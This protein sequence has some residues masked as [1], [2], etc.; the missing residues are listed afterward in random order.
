MPLYNPLSSTGDVPIG[1]IL[2]WSGL[3]SAIPSGYALCDGSS[4]SPGPD[5][6]DRFIVGAKQDSGGVAK[7]NVSGSLL[8]S[9]GHATHSHTATGAAV[10]AHAGTAVSTHTLSTNVAIDAHAG[11]AVSTHTL[12]TNVS[13]TASHATVA[14]MAS[15]T[16]R[17][18][19]PTTTVAVG[20]TQPV[21]AAHSV[22]QPNAHAITQPVVAAHSVTQ[23]NAH[24]ITQPTISTTGTDESIPPFFALAFM[25][26][27]S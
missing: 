23:P 10:D 16:T 12:S 27:M 7:T 13:V 22:T 15:G 21:V 8:Q 4:N 24:S 18:G 11:T 26:R 14:S 5:L 3:I 17:V 1:A 2:M 9:G 19:T 25:Q 6:R 20:V